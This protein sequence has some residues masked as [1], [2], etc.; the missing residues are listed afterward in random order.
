LLK[1]AGW[2]VQPEVSYSIFGERGS[3]DLLAWHSLTGVLLVI[4][5]KTDL[6]S[7]E[8]TQRKHDEK[9]R[10]ARQIA[11]EQVGWK[12]IV[13]EQV[14]RTATAVARLL[15]LPDTTTSRRRVGRHASVID[16]AYPLQGREVRHWLAEP[17]G[18]MAGLLFIAPANPSAYGTRPAIGRKRIREQKPAA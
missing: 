14:G 4:E 1:A 8:E 17:S 7:L 9:T 11:A 6:V 2:H 16:G 12:A 3:I 13:A 18:R 5:V 15:I 10:L